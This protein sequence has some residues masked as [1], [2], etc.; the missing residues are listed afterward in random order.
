MQRRVGKPVAAAQK[1]VLQNDFT[2]QI[3]ITF[4]VLL[5]LAERAPGFR[6]SYCLHIAVPF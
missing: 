3:G 6:L 1:I 2:G 5:K 4:V